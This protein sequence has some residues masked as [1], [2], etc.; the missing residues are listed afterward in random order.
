MRN[1]G[2][3][4]P[5]FYHHYYRHMNL[6]SPWSA[7][8]RILRVPRRVLDELEIEVEHCADPTA[9]T[10]LLARQTFEAV[11]VDCAEEYNLSLL[12]SIRMGQRNKKSVA[13]AIIDE[14]T[15]IDH[16]KT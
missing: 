8:T 7:R 5:R 11:I 6:Q 14:Q 12:K 13:V 15:V 16:L 10:K 2:S 1:L 4:R 9:A 3:F